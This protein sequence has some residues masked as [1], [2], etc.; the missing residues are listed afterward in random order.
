MKISNVYLDFPWNSIT[1]KPEP[2]HYQPFNVLFENSFVNKCHS[3]NK[4]PSQ[5]NSRNTLLKA[6]I[7]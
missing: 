3:K 2:K 6:S 4:L 1:I 7:K 5:K